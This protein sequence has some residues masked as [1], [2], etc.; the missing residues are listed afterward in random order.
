MHKLDAKDWKILRQLCQN[1]RIS[2]SQL[3]R[4]VGLSKNA[5]TYRVERL[6]KKGIITK[7]FAI[8]DYSKLGYSF[9]EVLLKLHI[10]KEDEPAVIDYFKTN[11]TIS[12]ADRFSGEFN[13]LLELGCKSSNEFFSF[14]GG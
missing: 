6:K 1:A 11:P 8:V 14:F 2:H 9:Y 10:K 3:A 5:V 4:A 12:V 7:F 13:F